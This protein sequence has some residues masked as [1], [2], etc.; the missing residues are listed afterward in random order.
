MARDITISGNG[1]FVSFSSDN[2]TIVA[3]D[4]NGEEDVFVRRMR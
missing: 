3:S 1:R 4:T 2:G